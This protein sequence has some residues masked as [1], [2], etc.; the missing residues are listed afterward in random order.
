MTTKTPGPAP[1]V[2]SRRPG[3]RRPTLAALASGAAGF[4]FA[5]A[6]MGSAGW[7]ESAAAQ[8]LSNHDSSAPVDFSADS[9][10]LQSRADRAVFSGNVV[11]HQAGL[12]LTASRMT[13]AYSNNGSVDINRIDATGGV[14]ITKG[15]ENARGNSAI[16]DLDRRLITLIGSVQLNQ[17]GNRLEGSR[18][19]IDLTSGRASINGRGAPAAAGAPPGT[20]SGAGGRVTGRFTVPKRN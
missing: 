7:L 13:F 6:L 3:L 18:M 8:A 11:V 16:Y 12:T 2:Q 1:V 5:L 10:E 14:T 15:D 4:A 19:V 9:I 17:A 20:A